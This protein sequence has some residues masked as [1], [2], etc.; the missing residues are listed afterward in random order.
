MH[1]NFLFYEKPKKLFVR[2]LCEICISIFYLSNQTTVFFSCYKPGLKTWDL[3]VKNHLFFVMGRLNSMLGWVLVGWKIKQENLRLLT[4]S[5]RY[6][7]PVFFCLN[8]H[9]PVKIINQY[10]SDIHPNTTVFMNDIHSHQVSKSWQ[11]FLIR[12]FPH[13]DD[14][15]FV[16]RDVLR[17][18]L[19]VEQNV[20]KSCFL[21]GHFDLLVT[22]LDDDGCLAEVI[23]VPE[24]P[25]F[26]FERKVI[27][28]VDICGM[29]WE[30]ES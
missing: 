10:L 26:S 14:L 20:L 28:L 13:S 24:G 2:S 1:V 30:D 12:L 21:C 15:L 3:I 22:S 8:I 7:I 9:Q 18:I 27:I 6:E 16:V 29:N 25:H 23:G 19:W 5:I 11:S 4:E 17:Q